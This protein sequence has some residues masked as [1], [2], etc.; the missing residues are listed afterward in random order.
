MQYIYFGLIPFLLAGW[1]VYR[2]NY[3]RDTNLHDPMTSKDYRAVSYVYLLIFTG[4]Y[5]WFFG[6]ITGLL[7]GLSVLIVW[8]VWSN[9]VRNIQSKRTK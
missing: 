5:I 6:F 1:F 2:E 9:S 4:M 7:S 3:K 8:I